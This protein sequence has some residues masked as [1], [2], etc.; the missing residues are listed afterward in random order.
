MSGINDLE[1]EAEDTES[2]KDNKEGKHISWKGSPQSSKEELPVAAGSSS[3][4]EEEEEEKEKHVSWKGSPSAS[5]S[6]SKEELAAS[7]SSTE[8]GDGKH[9]SWRGSPPPIPIPS[10]AEN[11]YPKE[12]E[13]LTIEEH[14]YR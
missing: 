10:K 3:G 5:A 8:E 6:S 2:S 14:G 13:S 4:A 1:A 7:G 9:V 11:G 12:G